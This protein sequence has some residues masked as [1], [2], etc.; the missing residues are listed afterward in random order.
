MS[1]NRF[2][3]Y[4]QGIIGLNLY[5]FKDKPRCVSTHVS[6]MLN[7]TQ[8]MFEY[9]GLPETIPKRVLE[10]F[11]QTNGHVCFYKHNGDLYVF[12]GTMGGRPDVYY[13][14]TEYIIANPGL[15]LSVSAKIDKDCVVIPNDSMY[16]GLLPMS[17]RYATMLTENELSMNIAS[18]NSRIVSLI[19]AGDDRTAKSAEKYLKDI[20]DGKQGV[21]GENSF[22]DGVKSQVYG[23]TA[24]SNAITNLIEHEQYIKASW[25]NE[26]G[27]NANY[28]MKREAINSGESQL[29][30]DM[31]LPLVDNMLECRENGLEKVNAMFGTN[32]T[33]RLASSWGYNAE[34]WEQISGKPESDEQEVIPSFEDGGADDGDSATE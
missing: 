23:N 32:I 26:L 19:S 31:L 15:N 4:T 13:M 33:V 9:D 17:E 6:Y 22:L 34:E 11:L 2:D 24:N 12:T 18:I 14:P 30:D 3:K 25:F 21:I 1:I 29:N 27:L 8:S 5:D 7:R 16:L 10:L 28:N 20:A